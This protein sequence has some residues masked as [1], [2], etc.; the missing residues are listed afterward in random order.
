MAAIGGALGLFT[1]ISVISVM[2]I[3]YWVT[4]SAASLV[5]KVNIPEK[6]KEEDAEDGDSNSIANPSVIQVRV[7]PAPQPGGYQFQN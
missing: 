4:R 5:C 6:N 2:E 1:G 7:S 3:L